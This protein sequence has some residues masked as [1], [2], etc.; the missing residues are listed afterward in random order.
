ML[1]RMEDLLSTVYLVTAM[2]DRY[3]VIP[4]LVF[5]AIAELVPSGINVKNACQI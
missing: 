4:R 2:E 1:L 3:P 5:A